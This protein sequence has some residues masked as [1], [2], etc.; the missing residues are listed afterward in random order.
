M[1]IGLLCKRL[2]TNKDL[3]DDRFGRLYHLPVQ[4]TR[5]GHEV[6]VVAL[7]YRR[8]R[9]REEF[10]RDNVHFI[11]LPAIG[12]VNTPRA[13][14]QSLDAMRVVNPDI[15]VASGDTYLGAMAS[16]ISR[17]MK[18]PWVFD[19]YDDYRTFSS[20]R[21]PGMQRLLKA[22]VRSAEALMVASAP[23]R[24]IFSPFNGNC[25]IVENGTDLDLFHPMDRLECRRALGIGA[26]LTVI[27]YFGSIESRRGM[28]TLIAAVELCKEQYPKT[29][30]LVSG[31]KD[32]NLDLSENSV[33]YRGQRPQSEVPLLINACDVVTIP[34]EKDPY[35]ETTNACKISEYLACEVPIVATKVSDMESLFAATPQILADPGDPSSLS[36]AILRQ[37]HEPVTPH[38]ANTLTWEALARRTENALIRACREAGKC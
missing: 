8:G 37:L 35:I 23:L 13:M 27:G 2:Y 34:Y 10:D 15:I 33:D 12:A 4:L 14:I 21:I 6:S 20:A 16:V 19:I 26:D 18:V 7:D 31:K 22:T 24:K 36:R 3:I 11:S 30:L 29:H 38:F 28:R 17:T 1:K 9:P 32:S 5:L 25:H